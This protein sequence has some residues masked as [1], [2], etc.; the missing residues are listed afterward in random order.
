MPKQQDRSKFCTLCKSSKFLRFLSFATTEHNE[1][2]EFIVDRHLYV[3]TLGELIQRA[4]GC[5]SCGIVFQILEEQ[6][7]TK[8]LAR[9]QH[10]VFEEWQRWLTLN[11]QQ[12]RHDPS[13]GY[14][15]IG[16]KFS[17]ETERG[18]SSLQ[19]NNVFQVTRQNPQ[20]L[21]S[22]TEKVEFSHAETKSAPITR[23]RPD[24]CNLDLVRK[25]LLI[26]ENSH[27]NNCRP[28]RKQKL[29]TI[30]LVDTQEKC[31]KNFV[32]TQD[33]S[34]PRYAALSYVWG[35]TVSSYGL[36]TNDLDHAHKRGFLDSVRLPAT[37]MDAIS[38]VDSVGERYL[39]V[40]RLCI[41]QDDSN[42]KMRYIP[43]M[44]AIY[45]ESYFTIIASAGANSNA[46][47]P[48]VRPGIRSYRQHSISFGSVCLTSCLDPQFQYHMEDLS[49]YAWQQRA[50][51]FQEKLLSPRCLIF[52]SKQIY[53]ECLTASFSEET[54]FEFLPNG[55][56]PRQI[57]SIFSWEVMQQNHAMPNYHPTFHKRFKSLV[58]NYNRRMLSLDSDVLNAIQGVLA[59]L[60]DI[61]GVSFYW[62]LPD[63]M[64]EHHLLWSIAS[65]EKR[66]IQGFPTWSWLGYRGCSLVN[67]RNLRRRAV[68]QCFMRAQPK[69][70]GKDIKESL[71]RVCKD[72]H[73]FIHLGGY[74][75]N[76][77]ELNVNDISPSTLKHV[78]PAFHLIFFADTLEVVWEKGSCDGYTGK[79]YTLGESSTALSDQPL[80]RVDSGALQST[81]QKRFIG[82]ALY[83][84]A[85][86]NSL[87]RALCHMIK[88]IKPEEDPHYEHNTLLVVFT[89]EGIAER[90]GQAHVFADLA[91]TLA[92]SKKLIVLG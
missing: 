43:D 38:L 19:L 86:R 60:T 40:D 73:C 85:R 35:P 49:T 15:Q 62:G 36:L 92:W 18:G 84:P 44:G 26:C 10:F 25:W 76:L 51:T 9:R 57:S 42:D 61:T 28:V 78:V 37:L 32:Q 24:V 8:E 1:T 69:Y 22:Q 20:I 80:D 2:S 52:D 46:G 77:Q 53:W 55:T 83:E 58:E 14:Y 90:I 33:L 72:F 71:Q 64:F 3:G 7:V 23:L 30:R 45:A 16:L 21:S 17:A 47:L 68:I 56:T 63:S 59:V 34:I 12:Y 87:A 50:W 75:S 67:L 54:T 48:G 29:S 6:S 31:I 5:P 39:W 79:L 70:K 91:D 74:A 81:E 27:S 82:T 88:I 89:T 4:S 13:C 11:K 65:R 41:L 66:E